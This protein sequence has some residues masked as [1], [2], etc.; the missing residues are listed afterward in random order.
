M[1][2]KIVF[3]L[4][5]ILPLS[6]LRADGYAV[7]EYDEIF[8]GKALPEFMS[9]TEDGSGSLKLDDIRVYADDKF[10]PVSDVGLKMG[11]SSSVYWVKFQVNNSESETRK[12]LMESRYTLLDYVDVYT[13]YNHRLVDKQQ[14]GDKR[15][16]S[17]RRVP[18]RNPVF[19]I[20]LKPGISTFYVRIQTKGSVNFNPKFWHSQYFQHYHLAEYI[21][22][23][24][25]FGSLIVML[26]YNFFLALSFKSKTYYIYVVYIFS[27]ILYQLSVTG[28]GN[29]YLEPDVV[30]SFIQNKGLLVAIPFSY[31]LAVRF[32]IYFFDMR[33]RTRRWCNVFRVAE[34]FYASLTISAFFGDYDLMAKLANIGAAVGSFMMLVNGIYNIVIGY[35]PALF[36]TFA[37]MGLLCGTFSFALSVQGI[38]PVNF[39]ST[40]AQS[41]GGVAEVVLLSLALGA[42]VNF[43]RNQQEKEIT[44]LNVKL[45]HYIEGIEEIVREK[46]QDIKSILKN[47]K[48]G[49][50]TIQADPVN[51][52]VAVV[53]E[54]VSDYLSEFIDFKD[55]NGKSVTELIFA[56]SDLSED[57]KNQVDAFIMASINEDELNFSA[58]LGVL[59]IEFKMTGR[60]NKQKIVEIDWNP[61]VN[62]ENDLL[63]KILV[64]M[65][66]VT[67]LRKLQED[68]KKQQEETSLISEVLNID[69]RKFNRFIDSAIETFED[70]IKIL[71][72]NDDFDRAD[73]LRRL[74]VN[75]HTS[76]GISRSYGLQKLSSQFHSIENYY[77]QILKNDHVDWDQDRIIRELQDTL[78]VIRLY[79]TINDEKLNRNQNLIAINIHSERLNEIKDYLDAIN[80]KELSFENRKLVNQAKRRIASDSWYGIQE[81]RE[82]VASITKQLA[83]ELNKEVPVI[84]I[85]G[86]EFWLNQEGGDLLSKILTHTLRNAMDHGIETTK[87]R[88]AKNKTPYGVISI[89]FRRDSSGLIMSLHDDGGGL[90]LEKVYHKGLQ[91][92]RLQASHSYSPDQIVNLIFEDGLS[93]AERVSDISGRGIG[94]GAIKRFIVEAGGGLTVSLNDEDKRSKSK[95]LHFTLLFTIPNDLTITLQEAG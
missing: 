59:P 21:F 31:L 66:D 94:M 4:L 90:N 65:R 19:E 87:E 85:E 78:E 24:C 88:I 77:S 81:L 95:N 55:S 36:Y 89:D 22:V 50:F 64:S 3:M 46:T 74:Y 37:W 40:W 23:G 49:I 60:D 45:K 54:D 25:V 63:E 71:A 47:I 28:I 52:E 57:Q 70:E 58:N 91:I 5:M 44:D 20:N 35:R 30:G 42:R 48:Q 76:K 92:G 27:F 69:V 9:Y 43:Y 73:F 17:N 79:K 7:P 29:Q 93:T 33:S 67:N 13:I 80:L 15:R 6:Q 62:G 12:I 32:A 38:L 2:R 26:S 68:A 11:F 83:V 53:G 72:S 75:T 1:L 39:F 61:V 56:N 51:A 10:Q 84:R 86:D 16:F 14:L 82:E 41:I 34:L 18:H 8:K